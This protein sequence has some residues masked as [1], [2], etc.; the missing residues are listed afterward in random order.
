MNRKIK[1]DPALA[2]EMRSDVFLANSMS[3]EEHDVVLGDVV[4]DLWCFS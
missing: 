2:M 3:E 4:G 1:R